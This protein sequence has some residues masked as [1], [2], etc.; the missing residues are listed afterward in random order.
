MNLAPDGLIAWLV[1]G[2]IAG[3]LAGQFMKGGAMARWAISSLVSW[4]RLS[5]VSFS[6]CCSQGAVSA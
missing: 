5:V 6:A 3:W 4:A 2:L 1:V